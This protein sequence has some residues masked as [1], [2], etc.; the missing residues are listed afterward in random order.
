MELWGVCRLKKSSSKQSCGVWNCTRTSSLSHYCQRPYLGQKLERLSKYCSPFKNH[1]EQLNGL[2]AFNFLVPIPARCWNWIC[3]SSLCKSSPLIP[4]TAWSS[5]WSQE[6][7]YKPHPPRGSFTRALFC[8]TAGPPSSFPAQPKTLM[9]CWCSMETAGDGWETV[10]WEIP[11]CQTAYRLLLP[12]DP[13]VNISLI[14]YPTGWYSHGMARR[15]QHDR[16]L[17]QGRTGHTWLQPCLPWGTEQP[18]LSRSSSSAAPD[19]GPPPE[20]AN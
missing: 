9:C 7:R 6:N 14:S 8:R 10:R 3:R 18:K 20:N 19:S 2:C 13:T 15:W 16:T 11:K 5:L 17:G 1:Q 4:C 12:W